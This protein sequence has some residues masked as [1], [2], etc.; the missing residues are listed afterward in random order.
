M[1]E[2]SELT[3]P[4]PESQAM[5]AEV[6]PEV[7]SEDPEVDSVAAEVAHQAEAASEVETSVVLEEVVTN[8]RP[9]N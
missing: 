2:T 1:V 3:S 8:K 5:V 4:A 7:A 6:A 9:L